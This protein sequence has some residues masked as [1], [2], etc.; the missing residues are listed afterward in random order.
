MTPTP[1]KSE[2]V[3][4][5]TADGTIRIDAFF[6]D[7]TLWLTQSQM[8][9][10]FGV[11]RPAVIKHMKNIFESGELDGKLASSILEH[12]TRHG[13]LGVIQTVFLV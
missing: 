13:V 12:T 9:K 6:Q 2:L 1:G 5:K 8:A 11:Q 4:Y 7:E 3:L 10:L